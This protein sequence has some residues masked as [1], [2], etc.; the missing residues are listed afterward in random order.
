M[1]D[2]KDE[3]TKELTLPVTKAERFRANKLAAGLRQF[4]FW[5]TE[6]ESKEV[7]AFIDALRGK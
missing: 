3:A 4:S 7:K 5:L 2:E 1:K 6:H